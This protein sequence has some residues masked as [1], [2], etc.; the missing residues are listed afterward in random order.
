MTA[1]AHAPMPTSEKI[2]LDYFLDLELPEGF[3][4]ELIEGEIVVAPAPDGEHEDCLSTLIRQVLRK[5][6]TDMDVSGNKGIKLRTGARPA[7]D[8]VIPDATFAPRELR[9]FRQAP[10]WMRSEGVAMVV[11]VTSTRPE[12]DR[13]WKRHSYA[14]AGTPLYLLVDRDEDTATLFAEPSGDDY[15]VLHSALFGKPVPLPAPFSFDLDTSD[16]L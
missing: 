12:G 2:L 5:S 1:V 14:R 9:L 13:I 3:R 6:A 4:A 7:K 16:F 11:E 10:R 15:A 8:H